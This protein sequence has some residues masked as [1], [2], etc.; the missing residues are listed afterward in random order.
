MFEI[1]YVNAV[2]TLAFVNSVRHVANY[3]PHLFNPQHAHACHVAFRLYVEVHNTTSSDCIG[4]K[5][6]TLWRVLVCLLV[7]RVHAANGC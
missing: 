6:I 7:A 1:P 5:S 2:P 3:A 4:L